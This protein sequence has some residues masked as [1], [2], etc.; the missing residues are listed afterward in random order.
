MFKIQRPKKKNKKESD[1]MKI[2][3]QGD[4]DKLKQ[5]KLFECKK[6]GC[7]FEAEK[8]EYDIVNNDDYIYC[9]TLYRA[10]CPW[11]KNYVEKTSN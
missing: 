6:C 11:C 1:K 2:I 4:L 5:T 9:S 3:K 10:E 8:S 7:V